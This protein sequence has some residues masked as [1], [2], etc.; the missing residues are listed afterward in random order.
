MLQETRDKQDRHQPTD[1]TAEPKHPDEPVVEEQ[2]V[3]L[4]KPV[5]QVSLLASANGTEEEDNSA[6]RGSQ[7]TAEV[8]KQAEREFTGSGEMSRYTV[9]YETPK[10]KV[11]TKDY[12]QLLRVF[13]VDGYRMR[14]DCVCFRDRSKKQVSLPSDRWELVCSLICDIV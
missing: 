6:G 4:E 9:R 12:S 1:P 3:S 2:V 7:L 14:A 11:T 5:T 8:A 13:D 10:N